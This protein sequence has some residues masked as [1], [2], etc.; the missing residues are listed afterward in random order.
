MLVETSI[1]T[2]LCI[3]SNHCKLVLASCNQSHDLALCRVLN[4][5]CLEIFAQPK[6][7][8]AKYAY[9]AFSHKAEVAA[10][11]SQACCTLSE[12]MRKRNVPRKKR[13]IGVYFQQGYRVG[14]YLQTW[15]CMQTFLKFWVC[16]RC[17]FCMKGLNGGFGNV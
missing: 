17:V 15:V 9:A 6:D 8:L 10:R 14:L 16:L 3:L 7:D 2:V 11:A 1:E 4:D 12:L 5:S 13:K